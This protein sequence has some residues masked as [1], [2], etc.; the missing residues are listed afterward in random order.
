[1]RNLREQRIERKKRR[2]G[3]VALFL[4][5][6]M[7]GSV[8]G[9][10]MFQNPNATNAQFYGDYRFVFKQDHWEFALDG[11]V[12]QSFFLPQDVDYIGNPFISSQNLLLVH[13]PNMNASIEIFQSID[14]VKFNLRNQFSDYE[15]YFVRIDSRTNGCELADNTGTVI[16]FEYSNE[17][18]D[19]VQNGNCII[20]T[21]STGRE[22]LML[23][24]R[25]L[26]NLLDVI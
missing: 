12:W 25:I 23:G 11:E 8:I 5:F 20:A 15:N 19:L 17:T 3:I 4:V 21:G 6:T 26:Y 18:L 16:V 7:V 2:L 24:D 10:S 14:L 22:M 13:D 9:F 1:M